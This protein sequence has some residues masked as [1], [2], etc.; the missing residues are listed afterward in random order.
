MKSLQPLSRLHP[1]KPPTLHSFPPTPRTNLI[2]HLPTRIST[3]TPDKAT[4][5]TRLSTR[6]PITHKTPITPP[7]P[8]SRQSVSRGAA[9]SATLSYHSSAPRSA[10]HTPRG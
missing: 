7:S 10:V 5:A 1:H 6:R 2:P 9:A 3:I 8:S 4:L